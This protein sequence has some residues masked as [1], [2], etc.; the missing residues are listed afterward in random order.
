MGSPSRQVIKTAIVYP[1]ASLLVP[2]VE[3]TLMRGNRD[4]DRY[5]G[6]GIGEQHPQIGNLISVIGIGRDAAVQ[7]T[8]GHIT[9][10]GRHGQQDINT[11]HPYHPY[12][13]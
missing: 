7:R 10:S 8:I 3:N 11:P 5:H 2:L 1:W 9:A 6:T 4:D 13:Q 12:R